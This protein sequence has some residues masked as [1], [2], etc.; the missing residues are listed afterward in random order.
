MTQP[1]IT[2]SNAASV[3]DC[4]RLMESHKIRRVPVVDEQGRLCGIV[5]QADIAQHAPKSSTG[6]LVQEVSQGR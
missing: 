3:D 5:S 1:V 4:I 6:E 2:V